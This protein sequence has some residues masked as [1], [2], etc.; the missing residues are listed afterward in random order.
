MDPEPVGQRGAAESVGARAM[1]ETE[2]SSLFRDL[3]VHVWA[4]IHAQYPELLRGAS[5]GFVP[6]QC[7]ALP[8]H[9]CHFGSEL[10]IDQVVGWS[11]LRK[12]ALPPVAAN[13]TIREA[14][15]VVSDPAQAGV[16]PLPNVGVEALDLSALICSKVPHGAV[17]LIA[18][19]G[20]SKGIQVFAGASTPIPA[21][22]RVRDER[23][24][25]ELV[26]SRLSE[27]DLFVFAG[28]GVGNTPLGGCL[29]LT[30]A[31]G[32]PDHLDLFAGR[33]GA[34]MRVGAGALL[35]AC[36]TNWDG[37]G[38]GSGVLSLA[39]TLLARGAAF[40]TASMWW[41]ADNHA[42]LVSRE[43]LAALLDGAPPATAIIQATQ[44]LRALG[45]PRSRWAAY[46]LWLGQVPPELPTEQ[47]PNSDEGM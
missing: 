44:A 17:E 28:H 45:V 3:E 8:F 13:T 15:I 33:G 2:Q 38:M 25:P 5:V 11:Y 9:A 41:V 35:S 32:S 26:G 18:S 43:F 4:P 47:A 34:Q 1:W 22:A 29:V 20:A 31:E 16:R 19:S 30:D 14:L 23:P 40:V 24:T 46:C 37:T 21:C 42:P 39:S 12:P 36:E 6:G 27:C 10:I 7:A